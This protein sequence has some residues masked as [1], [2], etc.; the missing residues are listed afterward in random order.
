MLISLEEQ[1]DEF[2]FDFFFPKTYAQT[3]Y[4]VI[5]DTF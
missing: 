5:S 2:V 4:E 1:E 3:T